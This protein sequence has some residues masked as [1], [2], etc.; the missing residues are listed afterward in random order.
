MVTFNARS[1]RRDRI[2]PSVV[3]PTPHG[4]RFSSAAVA[5]QLVGGS[6]ARE[7]PKHVHERGE[8]GPAAVEL[9]ATAD[10]HSRPLAARLDQLVYEP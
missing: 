1:V 7:R 4:P 6:V 8:R 10:E 2:V 9:D 3:R 5:V